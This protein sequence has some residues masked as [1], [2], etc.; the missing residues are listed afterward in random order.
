MCRLFVLDR[1]KILKDAFPLHFDCWQIIHS[2][3]PYRR[4]VNKNKLI[5]GT[6]ERINLMDINFTRTELLKKFKNL[7]GYPLRVTIFHRYPT[8]LK[9]D[10]LP[11]AFTGSYLM[12]DIWRSDGYT[13]VDGF[14][15]AC[16][17]KA[18]NF[19]AVNIP[20]VGI[21]FGW[22]ADNGTFVGKMNSS[23]LFIPM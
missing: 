16:A 15:L 18:M 22:K 9:V 21:D 13:G 10:E 14:I 7:H 23:Q 4:S 1:P 19:T 12:N 11:Q 3:F 17:A 8:A 6:L 2:F 20:Q 5:F